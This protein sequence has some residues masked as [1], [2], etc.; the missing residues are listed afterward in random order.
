MALPQPHLSHISPSKSEAVSAL[1]CRA[2]GGGREVE[3]R[4]ATEVK[5]RLRETASARNCLATATNEG[6][7]TEAVTHYRGAAV[8]GRSQA[9]R[10]TVRPVR[11]G[12]ITTEVVKR[13]ASTK[14]KKVARYRSDL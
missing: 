1:T 5:A 9:F 11:T 2:I 7:A 10:S 4:P 3:E 14:R 13:N 8:L 12:R 6:E